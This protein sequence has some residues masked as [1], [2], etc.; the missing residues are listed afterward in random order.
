MSKKPETKGVGPMM[1]MLKVFLGCIETRTLA[2]KDS[3]CHLILKQI[4]KDNR[5]I[6][7]GKTNR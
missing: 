3:P 6:K 1:T 7:N 5:H 4:I 2:R